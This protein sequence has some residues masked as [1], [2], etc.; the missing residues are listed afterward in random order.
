[1]YNW[2]TLKVQVSYFT[3][4]FIFDRKTEKKKK[5]VIFFM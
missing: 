2:D 1:M 3:K 4:Q 5:K